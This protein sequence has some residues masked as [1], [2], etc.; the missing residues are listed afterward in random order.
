MHARGVIEGKFQDKKVFTGLVE[1]MVTRVD[2]D[3]RG[4]G[5]QGFKYAPGVVEF[6]HILQTYGSSGYN[7]AKK[8][9]ATTYWALTSVSSIFECPLISSAY[10]ESYRINRAHQP[11]F[12]VGITDATFEAVVS[13]LDKLNYCGPLCLACDNTQLLPALRP[14]HDKMKDV[15]Y[16]LGSDADEPL[17]AG[18]AMDKPL[19]NCCRL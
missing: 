15:Y 8:N 1:A 16:L 2:K 13:H 7:A 19:V 5:L 17:E 18:R 10:V 6:A 12:S 3:E 4:V 11:R 14:I 9:P